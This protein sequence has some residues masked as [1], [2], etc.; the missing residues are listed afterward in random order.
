MKEKSGNN[1]EIPTSIIF[2]KMKLNVYDNFE[3]YSQSSINKD[4]L[5]IRPVLIQVLQKMTMKMGFKSQTFFLSIY[6][7]DIIFCKNKRTKLNIY[8]AGLASFSLS[9]KYCENDPM[10][11]DLQYFIRL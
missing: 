1:V 5:S 8:K 4:Y 3:H 11:P 9:A 2:E 6:Y 10:V 7:L